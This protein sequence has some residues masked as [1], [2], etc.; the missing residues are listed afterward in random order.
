MFWHFFDMLPMGI[1][2]TRH[3]QTSG[4]LVQELNVC[5]VYRDKSCL[6]EIG[7]VGLSHASPCFMGEV[8]EIILCVC[9]LS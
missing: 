8:E 5:T 9:V 2:T 3:W 7:R 6:G 4:Q 1:C